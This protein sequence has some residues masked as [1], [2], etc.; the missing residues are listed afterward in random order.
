MASKTDFSPE[1]WEVV[2]GENINLKLA[3]QDPVVPLSPFPRWG[4]IKAEGNKRN[5]LQ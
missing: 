1:G 5:Q 2:G 3:S 4:E